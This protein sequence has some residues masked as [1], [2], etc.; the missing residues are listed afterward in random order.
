MTISTRELLPLK[1]IRSGEQHLVGGPD[2]DLDTI[3][4]WGRCAAFCSETES[5]KDG[6]PVD[7]HGPEC[8][9]RVLWAT[10]LDGKNVVV[11]V[12]RPYFHGRYD[13]EAYRAIGRARHEN[14]GHVEMFDDDFGDSR[15]VVLSS[16]EMRR[17]A[18]GLVRGADIADGLA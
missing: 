4:L 18:A 15:T 10:D 16:G 12:T 11:K 3:D 13:A 6:T 2:P 9:S 8:W 5:D 1:D 14:V 7:Q 17:P